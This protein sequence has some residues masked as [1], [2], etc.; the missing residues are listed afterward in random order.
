MIE[1]V[2]GGSKQKFR[3]IDWLRLPPDW[4]RDGTVLEERYTVTELNTSL[5]IIEIVWSDLLIQGNNAEVWPGAGRPDNDDWSWHPP[6]MAS[7][8]KSGV[9]QIIHWLASSFKLQRWKRETWSGPTQQFLW[10]QFGQ[11]KEIL[12]PWAPCQ[13]GQL[14]AWW[15]NLW[16]YLKS[17]E[18]MKQSKILLGSEQAWALSFTSNVKLKS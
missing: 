18:F 4:P 1:G 3:W 7:G 15:V 9:F 6:A 8:H 17:F 10:T 14:F 12:T 16:I 5:D 11:W 2:G 13:W